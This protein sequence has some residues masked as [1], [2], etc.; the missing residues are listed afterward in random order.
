MRNLLVIVA[1]AIATFTTAKQLDAKAG[2]QLQAQESGVSLNSDA[3][4]GTI[5]I[6]AK[7]DGRPIAMILDTERVGRC[8]TPLSSGCRP[9]IFRWHWSQNRSCECSM[10]PGRKTLG[11]KSAG[12]RRNLDRGSCRF[13]L[14]MLRRLPFRSLR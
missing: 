13:R 10:P 1:F 3:R 8:L 11:S 5:L 7:L 14:T 6:D 12:F 2:E 9:S 4:T